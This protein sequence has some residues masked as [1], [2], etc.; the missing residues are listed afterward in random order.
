MNKQIKMMAL[1]AVLGLMA[2]SCS[3]EN[4]MTGIG[5]VATS[6]SAIYIVE[7]QHYY[8]NPQT[9]EE[10]SAFLD[11][12]F[13]LAEEGYTVQFRRNGV[14]MSSAKEKV[15]YTTTS[16]SDAKA[17]CKQKVE[18]GYSVNMTYNQQTGVY[19][20]VAVR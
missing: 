17:W 2:A 8:S 15:T 20:C 9:E 3:K 16:L 6:Y 4:T 11:R 7:G 5:D 18:E 12:M 19:T 10:W 14:Q 1:L 13:A